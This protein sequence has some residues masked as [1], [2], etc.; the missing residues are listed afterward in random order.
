MVKTVFIMA[1]INNNGSKLNKRQPSNWQLYTEPARQRAQ[2]DGMRRA[3]GNAQTQTQHQMANE[4]SNQGQATSKLAGR[5][6]AQLPPMISGST[7][8]VLRN[9]QDWQC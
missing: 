9:E 7:P 3:T 5:R 4:L 1:F 6:Q 8:G 2:R